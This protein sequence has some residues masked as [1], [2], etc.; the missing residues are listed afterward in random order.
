MIKSE[1]HLIPP[2]S[3]VKLIRKAGKKLKFRKTIYSARIFDL[4]DVGV[5]AQLQ[6]KLAHVNKTMGRGN[7]FQFD[8]KVLA[9]RKSEDGIDQVLVRWTPLN[10]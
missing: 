8:G 4:F 2:S 6:E 5:M 10:M 7:D 9:K 1:H 3:A